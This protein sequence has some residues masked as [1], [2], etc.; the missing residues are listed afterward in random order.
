M[1][2]MDNMERGTFGIEDS[3]GWGKALIW[4]QVLLARGAKVS[5]KYTENVRW[6]REGT[7]Y[8]RVQIEREIDGLFSMFAPSAPAYGTRNPIQPTFAP[9]TEPNRTAAEHFPLLLP[10]T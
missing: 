4:S 7:P 8:L 1:S 9:S 10:Q 3:T 6:E 5:T 2:V